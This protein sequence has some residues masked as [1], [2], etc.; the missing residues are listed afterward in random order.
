MRLSITSKLSLAFGLVALI[1]S[2]AGIYLALALGTVKSDYS[3]VLTLSAANK[4]ASDIMYGT[5]GQQS[6]IRGV[7]AYKNESL[8]E[9]YA[10]FA[11]VTEENIDA[12]SKAMRASDL[13]SA[14]EKAKLDELKPLNAQYADVAKRGF[15]LTAK[16]D[17]QAAAAMLQT[18]GPPIASRI[19][20]L[21][22]QL[23]SLVEAQTDKAT[24][25]I[26][27]QIVQTQRIGY[28]A[29]AVSI[30]LGLGAGLLLARSISR[31]VQE[32]A[33]VARRLGEGD[34]TV[35]E[36]QVK[37]RDEVGDMATA[38]NQMVAS[39][40][41]LLTGVN[42]GAASV[43]ASSSQLSAAAEQAA[44]AAQDAAQAVG[45]VAGG[46]G[47]QSRFA[48]DVRQTMAELQQT[49]QQVAAGASTSASEVSSASAMLGEMVSA[50]EEMASDAASVAK[51]TDAAARTARNG[52]AVVDRTLD[53][54]QR[55]RQ[56]VGVSAAKIKELEKL[57]SQIGD[58]TTAIGEI[59]D[60]TNL[61]ALNAAIEAARAGEHG[62]G[63]AVVAEEV[64]RLAE[65]ASNSTKQ[66]S[67]L[68]GSIQ[69]ETADA[70]RAME[71]GTVEVEGGSRLAGEAGRALAEILQTVERTATDVAG[72]AKAAAQVQQDA[73]RVVGAFDSM[74]AVTE[75]STAASEEMAAGS[76]QVTDAVARIADL[77]QDNAGAAQE[78]SA[79][80]EELS[81]ASEEVSV[82]ASSL[83]TIARDLQSQVARFKL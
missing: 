11:K 58:I 39:L 56:A 43:L 29:S 34:L 36:L 70:V 18:E 73:K 54:M 55:I 69:A 21:S 83:G 49:I 30:L 26:E 61:L 81:A 20:T 57:S 60:Q 78:L 17:Y 76:S 2:V 80:V 32:V 68:I 27:A 1:T 53:G 82:S 10:Q 64:R 40:R 24:A 59:A 63:F 4:A 42:A 45:Q 44:E 38:F 75:E 47:E 12:L 28:T 52:S 13:F 41:S 3:T 9:S 48:D 6:A 67:G 31:P 50:L 79:S 66:I 19:D 46:A 23:N 5:Q 74:A 25:V 62:R 22:S 8:K 15:D 65:R 7:V 33:R 77:S 35:E 51:G 37:S 14:E 72:I 16:G 71:A